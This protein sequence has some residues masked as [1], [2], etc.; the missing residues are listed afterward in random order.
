MQVNEKN[1]NIISL[2]ISYKLLMFYMTYNIKHVLYKASSSTTL[3]RTFHLQKFVLLFD[4]RL[5]RS[6]CSGLLQSTAYYISLLMGMYYV[7]YLLKQKWL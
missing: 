4:V 6:I 7:P 1:G 5:A 3:V 2:I